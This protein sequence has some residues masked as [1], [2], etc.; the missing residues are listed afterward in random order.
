MTNYEVWASVPGLPLY[1]VSTEGRVRS[2]GDAL[3]GGRIRK[4]RQKNNGYF[5]VNL[6]SRE[7]RRY[8]FRLVHRLVLEAFVGTAPE[9]FVACHGN[10]DRADNRLSN[11]RW[12]S[13]KDNEADKEAHGTRLRGEDTNSVKLTQEAVAHIRSVYSSRRGHRW[14]CSALAQKYGVNRC[15]ILRAAQGQWWSHV[16]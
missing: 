12:A 10:G 3:K 1:E 11:L 7:Q 4:L 2:T 8:S 14:G 16:G 6:W 15:T 9:G 5:E 13:Q